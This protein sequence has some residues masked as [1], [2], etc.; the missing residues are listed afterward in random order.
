VCVVV[1]PEIMWG[2]FTGMAEEDLKDMSE[3]DIV[4]GSHHEAL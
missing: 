2:N 1:E 3:E 4:S